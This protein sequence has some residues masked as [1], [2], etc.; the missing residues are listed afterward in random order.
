[1]YYDNSWDFARLHIAPVG[2]GTPIIERA[3]VGS[4]RPEAEQES[5]KYVC[6]S[7][8]FHRRNK[9]STT[10]WRGY[11]GS[12]GYLYGNKVVFRC[13][14]LSADG[15]ALPKERFIEVLSLLG[16][17]NADA[18]LHYCSKTLW[19]L[20]NSDLHTA[21]DFADAIHNTRYLKG[22]EEGLLL[23]PQSYWEIQIEPFREQYGQDYFSE[24]TSCVHPDTEVNSYFLMQSR[25]DK[26]EKSD[27]AKPNLLQATCRRIRAG[28]GHARSKK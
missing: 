1:M 24:F 5:D 21:Y 17:S 12:K 8:I 15:I 3:N 4:D 6:P 19:D 16:T 11:Y 23:W 20:S 13:L 25:N 7:W 28:R 22:L 27:G 2:E 14:M 10:H 26:G 9:C 18:W